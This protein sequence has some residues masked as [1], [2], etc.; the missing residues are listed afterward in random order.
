MPDH[1]HLSVRGPDDFQLGCWIGMLKQS[2]GKEIERT[3]TS[4]VIGQR[5]FFD[6]LLR[7]DESYAQK[8]NYVRDN[9]V[10]AGFVTK[11]DDWRYS[12]DIVLIERA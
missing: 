10:R 6:H 11:A 12:G 1:V 2:L 9:P 5:G 4:H 8:W 3:A 7:S